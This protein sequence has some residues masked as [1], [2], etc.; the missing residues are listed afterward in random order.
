MIEEGG[1]E[2]SSRESTREE[3]SACSLTLLNYTTEIYPPA[4]L[5]ITLSLSPLIFFIFI[6][7]SYYYEI[8][9]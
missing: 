8:L 5:S 7:A 2:L 6:L 1:G 4:V 9:L 3:A